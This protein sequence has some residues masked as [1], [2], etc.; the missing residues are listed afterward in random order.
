MKKKKGGPSAKIRAV[1][2]NMTGQRLAPKTHVTLQ[3]KM[4]L[5]PSWWISADEGHNRP[6]AARC[7]DG[8]AGRE[9]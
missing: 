7:L 6:G 4:V 8:S 1:Q 9:E 3:W 2:N 5:A